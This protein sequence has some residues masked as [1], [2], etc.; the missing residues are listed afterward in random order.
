VSE[1][2]ILVSVI[3]LLPWMVLLLRQCVSRTF[4]VLIIWLLIAP[5]VTNFSRGMGNITLN[6][7]S[8]I[9]TR[10]FDQKAAKITLYKLFKPTRALFILLL[11]VFALEYITYSRR[12]APLDRTEIEMGIYSLLL[13]GSVL[14]KS[15]R[16]AFGLHVAI[17][18]FIVPF[19]AYYLT[20]RLVTS[21]SRFRQLTAAIGY[22]GAYIIIICLVESVLY[23]GYV[24][25]WS[26]EF[27]YHRVTGLF[28]KRDLLA[29]VMAVVFFA[30]LAELFGGKDSTD[31]K[32]AL[33]R[34]VSWFVILLAPVVTLLTYTR[35]SW[36][37]FA[38]GLGVMLFLGRRL[39]NFSSKIGFIGI[40]LILLPVILVGV[41]F[42]AS[43]DFT[44]GRVGNV[45]NLYGR[46]ATWQ[47]TIDEAA[48]NPVFGIGLN[49]LYSELRTEKTEYGGFSGYT[50]P[51]NA[52]LAIFA[53]LGLAGLLLYLAITT[54]IFQMGL[55]L[56]RR[57]AC[58]KDRWRG[59]A[60]IG[61]MV[62]YHVPAL[63][64]HLIYHA[65]VAHV[66]VYAFAGSVAG[67]YN[68][69]LAAPALSPS[70]SDRRVLS[71]P[72]SPIPT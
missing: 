60:V 31:G 65:S 52:F 20:R 62:A 56:Y 10:D 11:G 46:F 66:Y 32:R 54:A 30:V 1:V 61:I 3:C 64:E 8:T 34:S 59:L 24:D 45:A 18:A 51:H 72:P 70:A 16:L 14:L 25:R 4:L 9:Q 21:E 17:D 36:V 48:K 67:L 38:M 69:G 2:L 42:V 49:N 15:R 41:K 13:I 40:A 19:L 23:R 37:G 6:Q 53:E 35:G 55:R 68:S 57:G 28:E 71:A 39:I 63:F 12:P 7:T 43:K 47:A 58:F 29:I 26:G 44:E 27:E 22:M 50:T 5:V 33:P